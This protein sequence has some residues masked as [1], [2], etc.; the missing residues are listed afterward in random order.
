M[1]VINSVLLSCK[2]VISAEC[3]EYHLWFVNSVTSSHMKKLTSH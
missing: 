1:H 2:W 3:V